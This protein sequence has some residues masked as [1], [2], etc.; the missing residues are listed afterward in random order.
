MTNE[1]YVPTGS[2]RIYED[3]A[4]RHAAVQVYIMTT[5]VYEGGPTTEE[6]I[7]SLD[8]LASPILWLSSF[9]VSSWKKPLSDG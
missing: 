9:V 8:P 6:A 4:E 7:L 1:I 3:K 2:R 5:T